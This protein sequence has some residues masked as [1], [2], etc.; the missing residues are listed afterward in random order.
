MNE[1]MNEWMEWMNEWM[2]EWMKNRYK[3]TNKIMNY[4]KENIT[5]DFPTNIMSLKVCAWLSEISSRHGRT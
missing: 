3:Q 2:N 4:E 1:W 5:A